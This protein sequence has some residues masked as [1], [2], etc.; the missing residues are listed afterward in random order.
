MCAG[1]ITR[2]DTAF[3]GFYAV[4]PEYQGLGIGRELWVRTVSRL[5][6]AGINKGLYGVPGMS[7]KYK[8]SGF[9][10]EDTI[11][12]IVYESTRNASRPVNTE[13][14]KDIDE[15]PGC[16]LITIDH[17]TDDITFQK[18]VDY[19]QSVQKHSREK[20]LKL[21]LAGQDA[22][23]T[24]AIVRDCVGFGSASKPLDHCAPVHHVPERKSSCCAKPNQESIFEGEALKTST[25][26]SSSAMI[27][28]GSSEVFSPRATSPIDIPSP[29]AVANQPSHCALETSS[30]WSNESQNLE[31]LGYGCIRLDNNA[32]GM[33]GPIYADSSDLCEV[34]LRNLID[35]YHLRPNAIY[36]VMAL[37]SNKNACKLLNK[38]GLNEMDQCSRMFT[39]FVPAASFSKIFYVHSPNFSLF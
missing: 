17:E 28:A 32:G 33:I 26:R 37:S 24:I 4:E 5:D 27:S 11:R 22:P 8:K 13:E 39:K 34:I 16:R 7:S 12:M 1:T 30:N 31:L 36:S 21:Y 14:L 3:M 18:L 6:L 20:L 38:I 25:R 2:S 19:D 23:L 35:R 29:S 15:L 10:I 9:A